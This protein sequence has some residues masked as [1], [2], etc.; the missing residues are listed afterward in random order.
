VA[1]ESGEAKAGEAVLCPPGVPFRREAIGTLDFHYLQFRLGV[2]SPEGPLEFPHSGKLPFRDTARLLSTLT[3]L[4]EGRDHVSLHYLEHLICDMLYQYIGERAARRK[5][6][7]P[8]DP[9]IDEA[10]RYITERAC[11]NIS[12]QSVAALVG[13]SQSQFT[14]KFQKEMGISP[15][16]YWTGVRLHKVR[17]M[18]AETDEP[19]ERI[20]ELCGYQ[21]AFYLSRVFSKE[22]KTSPSQYRSA[23][24]V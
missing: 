7:R 2:S 3:A 6:R 9:A 21:N 15:V 1:G 16:K 4:R 18:L 12:M 22:M 11:Q 8:R 10:V 17:R 13:L 24:R 19:L 23:H 14:R 5:E 20:A